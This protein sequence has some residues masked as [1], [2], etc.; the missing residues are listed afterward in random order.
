MGKALD[1]RALTIDQVRWDAI[2]SA[3]P[4]LA[5]DLQGLRRS[6]Q[7]VSLGQ[8]SWPLILRNQPAPQGFW[9]SASPASSEDDPTP[10][11]QE[12]TPVTQEFAVIAK[13]RYGSQVLIVRYRVLAHCGGGATKADQSIVRLAFNIGQV[14]IAWG[15]TV[16]MRVVVQE[17]Q[18]CG[19]AD[20]PIVVLPAKVE[21]KFDTTFKSHGESKVHLVTPLGIGFEPTLGR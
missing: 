21:L 11:T 7:F 12:F 6:P 14:S 15:W 17:P 13:N 16:D 10:A 20:A 8:K 4:D 2:G 9:L 19:T 3:A 18:G 1:L 5:N